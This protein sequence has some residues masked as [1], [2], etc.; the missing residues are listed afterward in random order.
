MPRA[1]LAERLVSGAGFIGG[2]AGGGSY[3]DGAA[4]GRRHFTAG[5]QRN[6]D[7]GAISYPAMNLPFPIREECPPG[8]CVCD[9]ERLLCDPQGDIRILRRTKQEE[10]RLIA[11]IEAARDPGRP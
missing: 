4:A 8:A 2:C 9:R 11:R 3:R 7:V 1:G 5:V 6:Y 10:K